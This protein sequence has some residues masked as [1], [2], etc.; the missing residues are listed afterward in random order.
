MAKSG[1]K[2]TFSKTKVQTDSIGELRLQTP[3]DPAASQNLFPIAFSR[4]G[5]SEMEKRDCCEKFNGWL[6]DAAPIS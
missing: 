2:R 4:N 1:R 6:R 5:P 3:P